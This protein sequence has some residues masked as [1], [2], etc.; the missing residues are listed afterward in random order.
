M[1]RLHSTLYSFVCSRVPQPFSPRP[2][3]SALSEEQIT[4][5]HELPQRITTSARLVTHMIASEWSTDLTDRLVYRLHYDVSETCH[6]RDWCYLIDWFDLTGFPFILRHTWLVPCDSL[7]VR[8]V[9]HWLRWNVW[10]T[11]WMSDWWTDWAAIHFTTS[12]TF[13]WSNDGWVV[14]LTLYITNS[15]NLFF[16]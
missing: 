8:L 11:W 6:A 15:I 14:R 1:I 5:G 16:F 12:M 7:M 13:Q 4:S 2:I 10:T 9:C 3:S